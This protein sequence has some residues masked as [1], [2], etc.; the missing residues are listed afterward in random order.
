VSVPDATV[1]ALALLGL[2][3]LLFL[4]GSE[5]DLRKSAGHWAGGSRCR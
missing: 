5:V 1:T 4:A 3:F 2:S